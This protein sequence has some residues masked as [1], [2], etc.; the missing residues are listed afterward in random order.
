MSVHF[1]DADGSA[2]ASAKRKFLH[3]ARR[4]FAEER[5]RYRIDDEAGVHFTVDEAF[6]NARIA[7]ITQ[8]GQPRYA[9]A[10]HLFEEAFLALDAHPPDGKGAIRSV[11]FAAENI[12][13]L[14][15]PSSNQLNSGEVLKNLKPAVDAIYADQKPAVHVAQK[16]I[17]AFKEWI[18]GAHFYRHE[19]GTEEPA[20]PP[21]DLAVFMVSQGAAHIRWLVKIDKG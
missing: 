14:M 5:V 6:E 16:Q 7:A 18:D 8:L 13:R 15:Y 9:G 1:Y 19:P 20:Q 4:V 2:T 12:F 10:R 11:F 17:S 21:L 3:G